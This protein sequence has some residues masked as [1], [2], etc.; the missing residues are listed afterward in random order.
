MEVYNPEWTAD[1]TCLLYARIRKM[2]KDFVN[3]RSYDKNPNHLK[4]AYS[5]PPDII[6]RVKL[7]SNEP[8]SDFKQRN[9][10]FLEIF[11]QFMEE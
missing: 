6:G 10:Q 8:K 3:D 1:G 7:S 11:L 5:I 2:T 9:G 4:Q